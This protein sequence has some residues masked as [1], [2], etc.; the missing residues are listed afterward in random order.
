MEL[1]SVKLTPGMRMTNYWCHWVETYLHHGGNEHGKY[2]QWEPQNVEQRQRH[3]C[4]LCIQDIMWGGEDIDSKG[5]HGNLQMKR[6]FDLHGTTAKVVRDTS[7]LGGSLIY[8]AKVVRGYCKSRG[9][10]QLIQ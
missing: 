4:L 6:I 1:P 7:K 3:K 10:F 9:S 2:R 5:C 8:M